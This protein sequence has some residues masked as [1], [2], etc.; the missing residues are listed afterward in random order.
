LYP[1]EGCILDV[2]NGVYQG[3]GYMLEEYNGLYP[4]EGC[5]LDVKNGVYQGEGCILDV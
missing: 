2:K 5:I 3:K 4:D 1:D